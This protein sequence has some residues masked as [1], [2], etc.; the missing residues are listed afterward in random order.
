MPILAVEPRDTS[1][2]SDMVTVAASLVTAGAI[3]AA[4]YYGRDILIPF[5]I[6]FLITFMLNPPVTWLI[7]RGLPKPISASVVLIT[8][9]LILAGVGVILGAQF[10]SIAVELPRYQ[11][12]ISAKL[13]DLQDAIKAPGIFDGVL[14]TVER[15]QKQIEAKEQK[16]SEGPAP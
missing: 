2:R 6:A 13:S 15:V 4:L 10:R 3:F 5:A 8:V 11:S 7:R 9:V 14:R 1:H 16:P 12:T